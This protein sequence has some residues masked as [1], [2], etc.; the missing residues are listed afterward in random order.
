ME[1]KCPR[2]GKVCESEVEPTSGQHVL[3]PFCGK[4]YSYQGSSR[5]VSKMNDAMKKENPFASPIAVMFRKIRGI[6]WGIPFLPQV[7][8][9]VVQSFV[10]I[11]LCVLFCTIGIVFNCYSIFCKLLAGTR[12]ELK[13]SDLVGKSAYAL[14]A[15]IYLILAAPCW[16]I[17]A[18]FMLLG[19]CW[20]RMSW[21]GL[22]L[23]SV[24]VGLLVFA[25]I[26][27][28]DC[29][30][31]WRGFFNNGSNCKTLESRTDQRQ[32]LTNTQ[33]IHPE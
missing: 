11:V 29:G 15:G 20:N 5:K 32:S 9:F 33:P 7:I 14:M 3:C 26:H 12:E 27:H 18:P 19:W 23:Y 24:L 25:G 2:C 31:L 13:D 10:L 30:D 17:V 28:S 1:I 8:Q 6:T 16:V 22:V 4:T 21:I